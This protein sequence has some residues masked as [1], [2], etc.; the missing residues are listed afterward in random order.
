[1]NENENLTELLDFR[2]FVRS[3]IELLIADGFSEKL[4]PNPVKGS[5]VVRTCLQLEREHTLGL[6]APL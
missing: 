4:L 6:Q 5:A 2:G 1:M 3:H